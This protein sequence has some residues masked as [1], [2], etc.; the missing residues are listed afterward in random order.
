VV[1]PSSSLVSTRIEGGGPN[2]APFVQ[3]NL[4][5]ELG[6]WGPSSSSRI[7]S[8]R[9]S[10]VWADRVGNLSGTPTLGMVSYLLVSNWADR[11]GKVS[12][13]NQLSGW[14]R[15]YS[16]RTGRI[17]SGKFRARGRF[18]DGRGAVPLDMLHV[19]TSIGVFRR[20]GGFYS[21]GPHSLDGFRSILNWTNWTVHLKAF[22]WPADFFKKKILK[23]IFL[24][25]RRIYFQPSSLI[26]KFNNIYK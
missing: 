1:G 7:D 14:S 4:P 16:Y 6:W 25:H 3:K 21:G 10:V 19:H 8:Y 26:K 17:G 24:L 18:R 12:G 2:W 9:G 15:I 22:L 20:S 13:K 11:V 23:K 5:A